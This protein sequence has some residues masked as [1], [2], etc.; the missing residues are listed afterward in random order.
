MMEVL[1][2]RVRRST[3]M[4]I[5][6]SM[7]LSLNNW[8]HSIIDIIPPSFVIYRPIIVCADECE[9]GSSHR[10]SHPSFIEM[11]DRHRGRSLSP[12]RKQ[13]YIDS[14]LVSCLFTVSTLFF[15]EVLRSKISRYYRP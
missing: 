10:S 13:Q 14:S 1:A 3:L 6:A 11:S 2:V 9:N 15:Q 4:R 8:H 5:L 12:N 7:S